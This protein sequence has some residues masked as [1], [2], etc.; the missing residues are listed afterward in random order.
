MQ[1]CILHG[2]K[3][4]RSLI[5][6]YLFSCARLWV[7]SPPQKKKTHTYT[8]K[9]PKLNNQKTHIHSTGEDL[10]GGASRVGEGRRGIY[11]HCNT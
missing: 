6:V 7:Q 10:E 11:P 3:K 1:S 8:K 2:I 4:G 9:N 5:L